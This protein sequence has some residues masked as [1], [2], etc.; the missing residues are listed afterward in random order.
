MV[1][2][3]SRLPNAAEK[4]RYVA[5]MFGRI[6]ARYDLMNTLMTGGRDHAWRR[7]TASLVTGGRVLD[8]GT[9]TG[10]L[11]MAIRDGA[12][13]ATVVGVDFTLPMLLAAPQD[14]A[15]AQADALRLPFANETFDAV[16]SAFV[17]RNLAD[18]ARG[19]AEQV[20]VLRP[21]GKLVILETTPGPRGPL[22][23]VFEVYFR[24]V[25]PRVGALVAGDASAY[26][27]LPESTLT[28]LEPGRLADVLSGAGLEGVRSRTL[29]FGSVAVTY[30]R[31]PLSNDAG[32]AG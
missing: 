23:V 25:V 21:G 6:A 31:K 17:V 1:A 3:V 7:F 20:R 8:V 9:G 26:T 22:R 32:D 14:L 19:V 15:L 13:R 2:R 16:T 24:R 27:Y 4:P 18:V 11:A 30:G 29:A 10:K 28:F 12:P 5:D